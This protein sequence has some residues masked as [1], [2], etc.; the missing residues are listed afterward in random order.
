MDAGAIA[1]QETFPIEDADTG[2]TL[3]TKCIKVGVELMVRL[4]DVAAR[5]PAQIP[6]AEQD[7]QR[8]ELLRRGGSARRAPL[9]GAVGEVGVRL[10]ACM[11][12]PSAAVALGT[13]DRHDRRAESS[14]WPSSPARGC[15]PTALP[16]TTKGGDD[17]SV[18]VACVDEWVSVN[19]VVDARGRRLRAADALDTLGEPVG[20]RS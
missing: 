17:G 14:A 5:D 11:R 4:V 8:A 1:Y 9:V 3:S 15:P 7:L 10:R 20:G 16:G 2:L 13:P 19:K 12:L 18:L 6:A